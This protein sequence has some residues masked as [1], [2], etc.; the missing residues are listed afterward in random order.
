MSSRTVGSTT[1]TG[2]PEEENC[3]KE[4][5]DLKEEDDVE[6]EVNENQDAKEEQ[7]YKCDQCGKSFRW[8]S[9]LIKH[10]ISHLP[11]GERCHQIN[12][13]EYPYKCDECERRF[14]WKYRLT[15]HQRIHVPFRRTSKCGTCGKL[16]RGDK[17]LQKHLLMHRYK[18]FKCDQCNKAYAEKRLLTQHKRSHI[19]KPLKCEQCEKRFIWKCR[20]VKHRLSHTRE[21]PHKCEVC[22]EGFSSKMTLICHQYLHSGEET[23]KCEHCDKIFTRKDNLRRHQR[24]GCPVS[25]CETRAAEG[26]ADFEAAGGTEQDVT[27]GHNKG[28]VAEEN[29]SDGGGMHQCDECDQ[30]FSKRSDLRYHF[31]TQHVELLATLKRCTACSAMFIRRHNRAGSQLIDPSICDACTAARYPAETNVPVGSI[32]GKLTEQN[33]ESDQPAETVVPAES[34]MLQPQRLELSDQDVGAEEK[35]S[36]PK[37]RSVPGVP[38]LNTMRSKRPPRRKRKPQN[39]SQCNKTFANKRALGKHLLSHATEEPPKGGKCG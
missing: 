33:L 24:R 18:P 26:E 16:F 9:R 1:D 38:V 22:G 20:L 10:Q 27:A 14:Q 36:I 11:V 32:E 7:L 21:R 31:Q 37:Q 15:K 2:M 35:D 17:S 28:T 13:N 29:P 4:R 3:N 19:E 25:K 30:V 12:K 5:E 6:E 23:T 8:K 39:C 34:L